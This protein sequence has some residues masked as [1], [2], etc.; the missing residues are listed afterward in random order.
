[1]FSLFQALSL[2]IGN[3]WLTLIVSRHLNISASTKKLCECSRIFLWQN[4]MEPSMTR[5]NT[6]RLMKLKFLMLVSR[7]SYLKNETWQCWDNCL[8]GKKYDWYDWKNEVSQ[9]GGA[10]MLSQKLKIFKHI[11]YACLTVIWFANSG[12][13]ELCEI[14]RQLIFLAMYLIFF[15]NKCS[16]ISK[17]YLWDTAHP[18]T[19]DIS[20]ISFWD[21]SHI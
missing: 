12:S 8:T 14:I 5:L 6:E 3:I 4:I 13:I 19:W 10:K 17:E 11:S 18:V 21:M 1:M 9:K 7:L 15:D 16:I 20:R 2:V